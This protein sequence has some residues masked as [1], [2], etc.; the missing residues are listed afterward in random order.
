M[1][2]KNSCLQLLYWNADGVH[3]KQQE[4]ADLAV[5]VLNVDI[6]ALC[7]TRLTN[8]LKLNIPGFYCYRQDKHCSG[9]GQGVAILV[10]SDIPHS[11]L[12][13]PTTT[14]LEAV[15]ILIQLTKTNIAVISAY[16]SPNKLLLTS[17]LNAILACGTQVL[18]MGDLNAKHPYWSP[19]TLNSRGNTLYHHMLDSEFI[20]FCN[21]KGLNNLARRGPAFLDMHIAGASFSGGSSSVRSTV[22]EFPCGLLSGLFSAFCPDDDTFLTPFCRGG[23]MFGL[24]T[25]ICC[26]K[27]GFTFIRLFDAGTSLG[28]EVVA[29][30]IPTA[31]GMHIARQRKQKKVIIQGTLSSNVN[32][33]AWKQKKFLVTG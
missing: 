9:T 32:S 15:G 28:T 24:A 7:E 26:C 10:R 33:K 14:N 6:I 21:R 18:I 22:T 20:P 29:S 25:E 23:V 3:K 19:G 16:Q 30:V 12:P 31:F 4:L 17:D 2:D 8:R 1:S 5:S 27:D 13:I 11:T